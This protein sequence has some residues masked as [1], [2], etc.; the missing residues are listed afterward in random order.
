MSIDNLEFIERHAK[1]TNVSADADKG[2][3]KQLGL[4]LVF[5]AVYIVGS[6]AVAMFLDIDRTLFVLAALIFIICTIIAYWAHRF[7]YRNKIREK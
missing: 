2:S 5:I 3:F 6:V 7:L 1:K 4:S